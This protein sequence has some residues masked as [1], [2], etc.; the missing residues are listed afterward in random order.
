MFVF[1]VHLGD[2]SRCPQS[3]DFHPSSC[4]LDTGINSTAQAREQGLGPNPGH[5]LCSRQARTLRGRERGTNILSKELQGVSL[6]ASPAVPAVSFPVERRPAG[7]SH[8]SHHSGLLCIPVLPQRA[9][10]RRI[11]PGLRQIRLSREQALFTI[12]WLQVCLRARR[13]GCPDRWRCP[14]PSSC[15]R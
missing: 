5:A 1:Q 7:L 10:P 11:L 14:S 13:A 9:F 6:R 4:S 15:P 12:S 3:W 8:S 2:N